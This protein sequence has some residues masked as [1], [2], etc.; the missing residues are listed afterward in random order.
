VLR[1]NPRRP[2]LSRPESHRAAIVLILLAACAGLYPSGTQAAV[3]VEVNGVGDEIESN[4]RAMLGLVRF[5]KREDLSEGAVR[6]LYRRSGSQVREALRPYGYYQPRIESELERSDGDWVARFSIELGEPVEIAAVDVRILGEGR[7]EPRF[8]SIIENSPLRAGRRLRHPEYDQ[9]RSRLQSAAA[10]LG[11]FEADFERHRLEVDPDAHSARIILHLQTG[12]RYRFGTI[13]LNQNILE[14]DLIDRILT[15]REGQ[16]YDADALLNTQYRLT[17]SLYF[18]NVL[19]ETRPR[20]EDQ[21]EVP[22]NIE[23]NPAAR[24]RIRTGIGYATDTRL[25]GILK[26]DWRRLNKAGHS[27]GTELRLAQNLS[28]LTGRYRIPIGDPIKERLLFNAGYAQEEL[29]DLESRRTTFGASHI[30]M[31]GGGWQR[32]IYTE[33]VNERTR[34]A[35][36]P[37]VRDLLVIPGIGMEKLVADDIL[38]PREGFRARGDLRG[39]PTLLG[40]PDSFLRIELEANRVD[41][42]GEKWRFFSRSSLGI[43]LVD[44]L[45]TLPASQRFFAGGDQSVRGYGF[46]TLGPRDAE[47]NVIGGRHLVFGSFEAERL[48][49]G[50]VALAAFVDAGNALDDFGDGLEASVGLGVNVHTPVGTVR[51]S[52]AR[53]VTESRGMRFH[54][55]IRPDL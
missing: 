31:R 43:G 41:S 14:E 30:T 45:G 27:A 37:A 4:V 49:W 54:L 28:E 2:R 7:D 8:R 47:G 21:L 12:P 51:I 17:D 39:S 48:V 26:V 20:D 44:E 10:A 16:Y 3:Q 11:Y 32:R 50:R 34:V 9:L 29:A 15:I 53:S 22:V 23:T 25:R 1:A 13:E 55:T 42:I 52:L 40:A 46:N 19:V 6:R 33:L 38:F 35:D 36:Q 24:Q 18:S 5:G